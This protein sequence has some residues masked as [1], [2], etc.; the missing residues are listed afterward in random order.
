M[1]EGWHVEDIKAAIR[2]KGI[3]LQDLARAHGRSDA[4]ISRAFLVPN[5]A[6]QQIIADHIGVPPQVIW[7]DR[8]EADGRAKEGLHKGGY[9]PKGRRPAMQKQDAA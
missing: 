1:S 2:K 3:F 4:A 7:P 5:P 6:V 8:Y 9:K